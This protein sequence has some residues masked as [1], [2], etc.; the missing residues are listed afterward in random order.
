MMPN[1]N[2]SFLKKGTDSLSKKSVI[3]GITNDKEVK[4]EKALLDLNELKN[5]MFEEK[6]QA[7]RDHSPANPTRPKMN[8]VTNNFFRETGYS[9]ASGT[10]FGHPKPQMNVS[11]GTFFS[12]TGANFNPANSLTNNIENLD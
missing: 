7:K 12:T 6:I 5:Q 1:Q 9:T 3:E 4:V 10:K 2:S 8:T 11:Q